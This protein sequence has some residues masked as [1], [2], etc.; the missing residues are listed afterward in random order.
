MPNGIQGGFQGRCY[1]KC[2]PYVVIAR[3]EATS[4]RGASLAFG[5]SPSG[6]LRVVLPRM[7][8]PRDCHGFFEASQ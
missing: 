7:Q 1:F 8:L 5:N 2:T 6:N 4:H 3:S